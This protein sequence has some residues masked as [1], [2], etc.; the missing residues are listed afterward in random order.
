MKQWNQIS[1]FGN[2]NEEANQSTIV[3]YLSESNLEKDLI[4]RSVE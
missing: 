4:E 2:E 3:Q 1:W